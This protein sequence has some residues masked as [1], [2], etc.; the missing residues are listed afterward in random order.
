[1]REALRDLRARHRRQRHES[2]EESCLLELHPGSER[3]AMYRRSVRSCR[4][5]AGLEPA[6]TLGPVP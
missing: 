6:Q 5:T 4:G 1:V 2:V 3:R